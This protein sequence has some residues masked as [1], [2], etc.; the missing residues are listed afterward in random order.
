MLARAAEVLL[1]RAVS[2]VGHAASMELSLEGGYI[3]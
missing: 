1:E 3:Y 2:V